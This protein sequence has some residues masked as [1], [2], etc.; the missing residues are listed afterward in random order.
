[1]SSIEHEWLRSAAGGQV[2]EFFAELGIVLPNRPGLEAAVSCFANPSAHNRDDRSPSCSVNLI[3]GL[4]HCQGCGAQGNA[5]QAAQL[6]RNDRDA[7]LLAQRYGLYKTVEKVE[8]VRLPTERKVKEWKVALRNNPM[9]LRRLWE[10]KAWTPYAIVRLGLG[11]DGERITFTIRNA[12]LKIVGIVR[13]LPGGSPKSLALPGSKR[14]LFPP[15]EI[16]HRRHRLFVVEG[17]GDAVALWGLGL[18]AVAV[19]GAGSWKRD[20][21]A[22]LYGRKVTVLTDADRQGRG[23]GE[24]IGQDLPS[25]EVVD[26]EPG[27][28]DGWD[29]GNLVHEASREGGIWQAERWLGRL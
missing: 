9:I 29:A 22:R 6:F 1:V 2:I 10:V 19:P 23:L 25:A 28:E 27:R 5:Y 15:P 7:A 24:R 14:L 26:V 4:W 8:K 18:K 21:T 11:W 3:T 12:K 13:Y 17:E 16:V 20:W